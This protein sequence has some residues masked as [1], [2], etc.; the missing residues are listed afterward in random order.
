MRILTW[1]I[2][3][4]ATADWKPNFTPLLE[5]LKAIN[6]DVIGLNEVIHPQSVDGATLP[7]L[8][9]LAAQL[10]MH[11]VF[12]PCDRWEAHLPMPES[13]YGNALLAR[14]PLIASAAH[15]LSPVE[16][17]VQRGLLEGRMLL[18]DGRTFT[19]YVTHL[20]H[21]SEDAREVQFRAARTWL[22]RDRN[23]PHILMGDLNAIDLW[24][25]TDRAEDLERVRQHHTGHNLL[26]GDKGVRVLPAIAKAGYVDL[27]RN[28]HAP[29][30]DSHL[31]SDVPLRID[32]ILASQSLAPQCT[33]CDILLDYDHVSDHRPVLAEFDF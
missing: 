30:A 13:S 9:E 17:K 19:A 2:H 20:D 4:W 32:F 29:G 25:F 1:N 12:G 14:W 6:A 33:R 5:S 15:H 11:F 3:G 7:A 16:G 22:V 26:G 27:F 18:P 23:R 8:E 24:D 10:G 31:P 28:F 21:T